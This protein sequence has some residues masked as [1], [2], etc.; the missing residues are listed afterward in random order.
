M[1][2]GVHKEKVA[3][4]Q[5][6]GGAVGDAISKRK[7]AK[8][9]TKSTFSQKT[10]EVG[11]IHKL[12]D[13]QLDSFLKRMDMEKRYTKH[14]EED[15]EKRREAKKAVGKML[16][17]V[18][19]IALPIVLGMAAQQ[20]AAKSGVFKTKAYVTRPAINVIRPAIGA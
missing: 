18:G 3:N 9:P 16:F 1:H 6:V 13:E 15:A 14:M 10:R 7:A 17:E 5:R 20:Y 19:R 2:W 11:G 12:S 4:A 8:N